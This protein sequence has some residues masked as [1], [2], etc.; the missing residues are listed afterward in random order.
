VELTIGNKMRITRNYFSNGTPKKWNDKHVYNGDDSPLAISA[1][2]GI[3]GHEAT[4][5]LQW[6]LLWDKSD[7]HYLNYI[8]EGFYNAKLDHEKAEPEIWTEKGRE[9]F[10]DFSSFV[11]RAYDASITNLFLDPTKSDEDKTEK[12]KEWMTKYD[13][14]ENVEEIK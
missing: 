10:K 9:K 2:L 4:H 8:I 14:L 12:L 3:L 13:S 11:K 7:R 1:W 5:I 6:K